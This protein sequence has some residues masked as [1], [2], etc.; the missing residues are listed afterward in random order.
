MSLAAP[1]AQLTGSLG[2][3]FEE[4]KPGHYGDW[5]AARISINSNSKS[6]HRLAQHIFSYKYFLYSTGDPTII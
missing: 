5:R 2:M 4:A 6:F 3:I 1:V